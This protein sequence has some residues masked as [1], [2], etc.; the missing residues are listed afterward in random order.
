[1]EITISVLANGSAELRTSKGHFV[2][3]DSEAEALGYA[4]GFRAG[5]NAAAKVLG[6]CP[7]FHIER[8]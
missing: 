5:Y 4:K 7:E 2:S 6:E 3:F 1:M 8:A